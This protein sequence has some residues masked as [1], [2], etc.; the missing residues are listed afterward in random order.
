MKK[1]LLSLMAA[2][3]LVASMA[4]VVLARPPVDLTPELKAAR[5]ATAKYN[6]VTKALADG[7]LATDDCVSSPPIP[8]NQGGMGFHYVNLGLMDTTVDLTTPEIL[9]YAPTEVGV[10]L[11][12]V[13]YVLP[14]GGPGD[15]VPPA[16]PPAPI[17]FGQTFNGPMEGHDGGPPHYDLH[18]WL[19]EGNPNGIFT[20]FNPNV[21]CN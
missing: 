19:W 7:Y 14:I 6:A 18:V 21:S 2:V 15:P 17:L 1:V 10:R 9:L 8:G 13:E 12:A 20:P 5:A 16:P 11:V 4:T 3:L